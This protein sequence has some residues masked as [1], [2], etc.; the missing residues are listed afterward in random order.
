MLGPVT[1]AAVGAS[2]QLLGRSRLREATV[3]TVESAPRRIWLLWW[4]PCTH[5]GVPT[6]STPQHTHQTLCTHSH[7][8]CL[9]HTTHTTCTPQ[10]THIT[11]ATHMHTHCTHSHTAHTTQAPASD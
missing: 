1:A 6:H 3:A 5:V 9:T 2:V 7:S 4:V 11:H 10:S 8:T